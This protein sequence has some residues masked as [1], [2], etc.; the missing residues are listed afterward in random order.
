MF[1]PKHQNEDNAAVP[2]LEKV[3]NN[4]VWI[5]SGHPFQSHQLFEGRTLHRIHFAKDD[6]RLWPVSELHRNDNVPSSSYFVR[7]NF[8]GSV[9]S[10][11]QLWKPG[12]CDVTKGTTHLQG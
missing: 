4:F 7:K 3:A 9:N 1:G 6:I 5:L 12:V 11:I 2:N 8:I 10:V